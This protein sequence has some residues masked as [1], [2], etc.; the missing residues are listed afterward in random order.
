VHVPAP[1]ADPYHTLTVA[2]DGLYFLVNDFSRW[3]ETDKILPLFSNA[4]AKVETS[5]K[6][7]FKA[8]SRGQC[9]RVD[10]EKPLLALGNILD[11]RTREK[12][13][14]DAFV[15]TL[16]FHGAPLVHRGRVF[17]G[18][19]EL[20]DGS[21]RSHVLCFDAGTGE[22][23]WRTFLSSF[24]PGPA[25]PHDL[26]LEGSPPCAGE[27]LVFY[28]TNTGTVAALR[29]GDGRI[30]WVFNTP[31]PRKDSR[32]ANVRRIF[33]L[34]GPLVYFKGV[35]FVTPQGSFRFLALDARTGAYR[36]GKPEFLYTYK[37]FERDEEQKT[38]DEKPG[39]ELKDEWDVRHFLG[40]PGGK[41]VVTSKRRLHVY[42]FFTEG[43]LYARAVLRKPLI[44]R[45]LVT[46]DRVLVP[47]EWG[48]EVFDLGRPRENLL[49]RQ[50][51]EEVSWTSM[52]EAWKRYEEGETKGEGPPPEDLGSNGANLM[53]FRGFHP[54]FCKNK[55]PRPGEGTVRDRFGNGPP[56]NQY[57][58]LHFP[59]V[60]RN[61][62]AVCPACGREVPVQKRTWVVVSTGKRIFT[63]EAHPGEEKSSGD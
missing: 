51:K 22:L 12:I 4:L 29:A 50:E 36:W 55:H 42:N 27:G 26:L 48:I 2:D 17:I 8:W 39:D 1:F 6:G 52:I 31:L 30:E 38:P 28:N 13:G 58:E 11:R 5:R 23:L 63:L 18:A 62:N 19:T 54:V 46:A 3:T 37:E 40:C 20:S 16:H 41:L 61:G 21:A 43:K 35:L 25:E 15:R 14:L 10:G 59:T 24:R 49:P 53:A 32:G 9:E 45:G 56:E 60:L 34:P 57:I 33:W 7:I 47:T 44:G